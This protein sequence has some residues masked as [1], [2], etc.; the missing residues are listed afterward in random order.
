MWLLGSGQACR[1]SA[2]SRPSTSHGK[3][4]AA[5]GTGRGLARTHAD[6]LFGA[7][8]RIRPWRNH[9]TLSS[10]VF[11]WTTHGGPML[12]KP[13]GSLTANPSNHCAEESG[14]SGRAARGRTRRC[15][16]GEEPHFQPQSVTLA[17]PRR[18][19]F[20]RGSSDTTAL[21]RRGV[22][23]AANC[24]AGTATTSWAWATRATPA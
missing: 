9:P 24:A 15:V 12:R 21:A 4:R 18:H 11:A 5:Q 13:R 22:H 10:H 7:S 23:S 16:R 2:H 1:G 19:A 6:Q 3:S 14:S 20:P 8:I 17:V